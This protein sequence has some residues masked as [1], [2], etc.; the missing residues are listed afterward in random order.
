MPFLA[1]MAHFMTQVNGH[2]VLKSKLLAFRYVPESHTS[3]NLA[4]VIF[5][6][7]KEALIL[8]K[9]RYIVCFCECIHCA[10]KSDWQIY[11]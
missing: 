9:V 4:H 2:L 10:N 11:T 1:L 7:L 3:K 8:G 5:N 6:I